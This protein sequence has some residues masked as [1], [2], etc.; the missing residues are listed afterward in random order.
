[1]SGSDHPEGALNHD[2]PAHHGRSDPSNGLAGVMVKAVLAIV[3]GWDTHGTRVDEE[4]LLDGGR[5]MDTSATPVIF[6]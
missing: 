2:A 5:S 4:S 6:G 3:D 1:M